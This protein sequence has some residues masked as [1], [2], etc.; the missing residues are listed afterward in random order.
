MIV[1]EMSATTKSLSSSQV[2]KRYDISRTTA[3][4][5]MHRIR[6]AMQSSQ[7]HP[8]DGEVQVDEFVFGGKENLKQGRSRDVKKKKIVGAVALTEKGKISRAYFMK[9]DDYSSHSLRGIFEKHISRDAKVLTDKWSG[10]KPLQKEFNIVDRHSDKGN[11]MKQ[12]HTVVHQIK[13]W[14][15]SVYSWVHEEHIQKYLD[16]YSYRINRSIYKQTIFHGLIERM[17]YSSPIT[18]QTIKISN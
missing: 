15:R 14:L 16:E 1:F 13:A 3:W 10:Y 2:A 4:A 7:K 17:I 6:T 9:I 8:I 11:S 18:Y 5:F 12:F